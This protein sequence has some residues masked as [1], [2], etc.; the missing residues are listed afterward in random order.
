MAVSKAAG[1]AVPS[2]TA[3]ARGRG[4]YLVGAAALLLLIPIASYFWFI[5]RYGVNTIYYDQWN[6]VALLTHTPY[7]FTSYS[8]HT[9]IGMLWIQ[10]N[11]SRTFFPNLIVLVLGALTHLNIVVELYL[12]AALHLIAFVLIVMAHRRDVAPMRLIFYLP[13]ALLMFTFG[14]YVNILFGYEMC[15]CLVI[16]ALAAT[17]LL[18]NLPR[19][20]W[21][22]LLAGIGAAGVGSYSALQGLLIWPAGLVVLLLKRR[23]RAMVL[24][25][26][27]AAVATTGLYFYHFNFTEAGGG[28]HSYVLAHPLAAAEFFFFAIG[29]L[30]GKQL[31]QG[32]GAS[33]PHV[34]AFGVAVFLLAVVCLTIYGRRRTPSRS[35]VGPALICF[36][37]LFAVWTTL[38][39][40]YVGLV[41]A[42]KSQYVTEDLLILVGCYLC[43]LDGW[44]T[45]LGRTVRQDW[46][47]ALL[48]GLRAAAIL[49]IVVE[50]EGG[51]ANGIPSG[52]TT[53]QQY[54]FGNL[55]TA[56][57]AEAP[58]SLIKSTLFP[59]AAYPFANIRDL[60]EAAK[61][62]RLSFFDTGEASRLERTSLPKTE[63]SPPKTSVVKP[64]D[65]ALLRGQQYLVAKTSGDYPMASVDFQIRSS[66]GQQVALLHSYRSPF[67]WLGAWRTTNL[68]NGTYTVQSIATDITGHS[69][70]SQAVRITLGN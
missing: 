28:S 34:V 41:V 3:D 56:H 26:L 50:V 1:A 57:A 20:S 51:I 33:D 10:H 61:R 29:D 9:T 47:R 22:V 69:G 65:G 42:S 8:G 43:L 60:A 5:H 14:Q 53:R 67:G 27:I 63:Y 2:D 19:L 54:Q 31:P 36:G 40:T 59:N 55:V 68:P 49:L 30:M 4:T 15:W 23:S 16:A 6:D 66:G 35:P 11:E 13:V 32:P 46:R 37:T 7:L 48:V 25:W 21:L 24:T 39:R 18:L 64:A 17:I 52:A 38:G 58:D 12:S 70:T 44:P 45:Q 62:D